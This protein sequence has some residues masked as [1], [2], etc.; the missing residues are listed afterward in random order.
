V[1]VDL[2]RNRRWVRG[3]VRRDG[4]ES[5]GRDA[6]R[7]GVL[8]WREV[9]VAADG[10]LGFGP[11]REGEGRRAKMRGFGNLSVRSRPGK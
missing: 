4:G 6:E 11:W 5:A 3:F 2:H 10:G 8:D 9:V 7:K 1:D